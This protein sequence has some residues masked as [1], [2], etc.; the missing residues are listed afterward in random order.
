MVHILV[1]AQ[2]DPQNLAELCRTVNRAL[3]HGSHH[4]VKLIDFCMRED[5]VARFMELIDLGRHK[6]GDK[7]EEIQAVLSEGVKIFG[8]DKPPPESR[9][10]DMFV[11]LHHNCVIVP[12][13]MRED[14]H[15]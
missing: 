12:I 1:L 5:Q 14:G 3:G 6:L 4:E 2:G 8:Y 9:G 15:H 11:Q 13:A 10:V 7:F